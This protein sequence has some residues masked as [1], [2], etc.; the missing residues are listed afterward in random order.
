MRENL[1]FK[2]DYDPEWQ[3]KSMQS[4]LSIELIEK[5]NHFQLERVA[6]A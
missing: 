2:A 5:S 3:K 4:D 1:N 6:D